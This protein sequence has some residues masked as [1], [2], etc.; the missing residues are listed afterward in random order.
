MSFKF[1]W[2]DTAL[3]LLEMNLNGETLNQDGLKELF[4]PAPHILE[5][6]D[7]TNDGKEL[8]IWTGLYTADAHRL[9]K[10]EN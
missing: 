4:A 5:D 3:R 9:S 10:Y 6:L 7:I 2:E 1:N 8:K